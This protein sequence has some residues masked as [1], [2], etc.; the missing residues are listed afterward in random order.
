MLRDVGLNVT[1]FFEKK[2]SL[3]RGNFLA[4]HFQA[5]TGFLHSISR[6]LPHGFWILTKKTL[7][8]WLFF[9]MGY[10]N[11]VQRLDNTDQRRFIKSHLPMDFLPNNLGKNWFWTS[12]S[13]ATKPYD[14]YLLQLFSALYEPCLQRLWILI[15]DRNE[16]NPGANKAKFCLQVFKKHFTFIDIETPKFKFKSSF[17]IYQKFHLY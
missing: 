14:V 17:P 3:C 6:N 10:K 1:L 8:K 11:T 13:N 5:W 16:N 15:W 2:N 12:Y 4:W 7:F 9:R